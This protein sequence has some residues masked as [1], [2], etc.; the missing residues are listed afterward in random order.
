MAPLFLALAFI[1]SSYAAELKLNQ[2]QEASFRGWFTRIVW[3]QFHFRPNQR[4]T[5]RDCAGLVRFALKESFIS[6]DRAWKHTNSIS[7]MLTP[8]EVDLG[9]E[10]KK[11][12]P[13]W[14][15]DRAIQVVQKYTRFI[16]KDVNQARPGD[17]LFYD[18][19]ETQHL[20]ISMGP[21]LAYHNGSAT[22]KDN[23]LRKQS[24]DHLMKW[25]DTRWRPLE[26][27]PNFIGI[28]RFLFLP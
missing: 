23:G 2:N 11:L 10:Q 24:I 20:M 19:G 5:H 14:T 22:K 6:H 15:Y 25:K 13:A 27:N 8:P 3:E 1:F 4:W 7:P 28:F 17:L 12:L 9:P 21:Y 18:F 16:S 26:H